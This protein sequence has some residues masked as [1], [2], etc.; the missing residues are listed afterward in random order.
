MKAERLARAGGIHE[1][2]RLASEGSE[3]YLKL[4]SAQAGN[5]EQPHRGTERLIDI[6]Q[7]VSV[8]QSPGQPQSPALDHST[9]KPPL[10]VGMV[11]GVAGI[12]QSDQVSRVIDATRGTG[13]QVMDVRLSL[14]TRVAASPANA[15]I[16]REND[17]SHR[18]PMRGLRLSRRLANARA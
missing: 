7:L 5:T 11:S 6:C 4:G 13:D 2:K 8:I 16:A 1:E 18:A 15:R 10:E 9:S 17:V 3:N 12:A 14:G